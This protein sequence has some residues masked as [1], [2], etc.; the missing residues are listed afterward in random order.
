MDQSFPSQSR[1]VGIGAAPGRL[2][3]FP[4]HLPAAFRAGFRHVE[5]LFFPGALFRHHPEH[6]RDDF[7]SLVDDYMVPDPDVPF[8]DEIFVVEGGPADGAAGEPHRPG[9][10]SRGQHPGASHLDHYVFQQSLRLFRR[11]LVS[12]GPAGILAGGSQ[13]VLLPHVVYLHHHPI[14]IVAQ[15]GPALSVFFN[16]FIGFLDGVHQCPP[17]GGGKPVLLEHIHGSVV[18]GQVAGSHPHSIGK[19][20]QGPPGGDPGIQLA[21]RTGRRIPAVGEFLL[22]GFLPFLIQLHESLPGH[23]H[24]S[25]H[26]QQFRDFHPRNG[27]QHFGDVGDGPDVFRDIFSHHSVPPG[28]SPDEPAVFVDD[29]AGQPVNLGLHHILDFGILRQPFM[30]PPVEFFHLFRGKGVGQ[31]Q[32]RRHMPDFREPGLGIAPHMLA[33]RIRSHQFRILCFQGLQFPHHGV[34]FRIGDQG[35]VLDIIQIG[36]FFH[37]GPQLV[38]PGCRRLFRHFTHTAPLLRSSPGSCTWWPAV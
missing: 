20:G 18:G 21:Q 1:A 29:A 2:P 32:Q 6:F 8:P 9:H 34:V 23:V 16:Q 19:E 12:H 26:I 25:P 10:C 35:I 5:F 38:D 15:D 7:R 14:G 4:F 17:F 22:P 37:D 33:G 31:A 28:G 3:G 30:D 13:D 36:I 27:L 24:F 11:E